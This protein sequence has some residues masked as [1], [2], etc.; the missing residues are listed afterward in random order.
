MPF[1]WNEIKH[2]AIKC[3]NDWKNETR[4]AA[5][6]QTFWNEFLDIFGP[7]KLLGAYKSAGQDLDKAP[8][9]LDRAVERCY[10]KE[11]FPN[12]SARVELLSMLYEKLTAPLVVEAKKTR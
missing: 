11:P 7:G 12:D 9:Y 1:S 10:R 2:R 8:A 3:G 5:E 4:E 6:R